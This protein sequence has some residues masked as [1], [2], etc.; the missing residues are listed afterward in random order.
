MNLLTLHALEIGYQNLKVAGP[1]SWQIPQGIRLGIIGGNG[2][3]KS[4]LVKTLLGIIPS[5]SGSYQWA[6]NTQFTYVPQEHQ[7]DRL[8]P[9]NVED[10]LKMGSLNQLSHF[11]LTSK[12]FEMKAAELLEKM[13]LLPLRKKLLR[14]LSGGQRQRALIARALM[15]EPEV[16]IMDEPHNSLDHQFR[17]KIWNVLEKLR[18]TR[19]F[20]WM[21]IDHDLN[22]ILTQIDR[23]RLMGQGKVFC[24][25]IQEI[26]NEKTLTEAYG[27]PV[28]VHEEN[29]R[30]QIHFL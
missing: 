5:L 7:M 4:S 6:E 19:S 22:R 27:E 29:G 11:K 13:E 26:L 17:E 2:S 1:L 23:I 8:F 25:P 30:F 15:C 24:G 16:L 21:V 12:K 10:I 14:E 18:Q 28:H 9:L 20:S 3:G